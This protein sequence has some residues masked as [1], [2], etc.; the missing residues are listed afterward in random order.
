MRD[1]S[2][3]P[4]RLAELLHGQAPVR[5]AQGEM[6]QHLSAWLRDDRGGLVEAPTG[7]GKSLVLLAAALDWVRAHPENQA[8]IATHTRQLQS[9]LAYDVQ[10]LSERGLAVLGTQADLVKGASNRLSLR[11]L[12]LELAD[13]TDPDQRRQTPR[14]LREFLIF[15]L[16]RLVSARRLTEQWEALSVDTVDVPMVFAHPSPSRLAGW[17]HRLS[18]REHGEFTADHAFV[19]SLHTDRVAEALA[20]GRIVIANHALLLAHRGDIAERAERA[21]RLAIFVDEAHDLEGAATEALSLTFDYQDLERIPRAIR[22]LVRECPKHPALERADQA[23]DRLERYLVTR[24]MP[25]AA[26]DA[27]DQ[28]S[29]TGAALGQRAATL[30]SPYSGRR[31]S[32]PTE[33]LRAGLE[34]AIRDLTHLHRCLAAYAGDPEGLDRAG[35]W[36]AERFFAASALVVDQESAVGPIVS[37]LDEVLG[38]RRR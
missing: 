7:T 34:R 4:Q 21:E 32:R 38:S 11:A 35:R 24:T 8:I 26:N 30:A 5:P 2:V 6:S 22:R 3:D 27:L 23:A 33:A 19:A 31:I 16:A 20:S 29:E 18:Q 14:E 13:A 1:V 17:L 25:A 28:L 15:L 9:Q 10:E 37:A 36:A 12:T